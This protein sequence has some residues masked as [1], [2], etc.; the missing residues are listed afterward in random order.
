MNPGKLQNSVSVR[1]ANY[2]ATFQVDRVGF[3]TQN[4]VGVAEEEL[5]QSYKESIFKKASKK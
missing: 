2:K 1:T 4:I 3:H 5:I